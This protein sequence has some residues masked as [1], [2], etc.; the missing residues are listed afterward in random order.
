[1]TANVG[2]K[3]GNFPSV[4]GL[5]RTDASGSFTPLQDAL[6]S[7]LGLVD[8]SGIVQT[9]YSYDPFGNTT[10]SGTANANPSQY[11]GRENEGNGLYFYRARYY[12]PLLGRFVNEDPLGFLG[13]GPNIHA[14]VGD[15]PIDFSDPS[16]L[17]PYWLGYLNPSNYDFSTYNV[18]DTVQDIGNLSESFTNTFTFGSASRLNDA[19]GAGQYVNRCGIGYKLGTAAGIVT[20]VVIIPNISTW[21]KNPLLYEVGSTTV[22]SAVYEGMQGLNAIEKGGYLLANYGWMG[23]LRLAGQAA[24]A[25]E[26]ATTIGTGL[27][28]GGWLAVIAAS[29]VTSSLTKPKCGC[30]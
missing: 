6:G 17:A 9:T 30:K 27:T 20:S 25:G 13:S 5:L 10:V 2:K 3:M 23:T 12:S 14:Y 7:T 16:G 26:Y 4:P 24:L 29:N 19:L 28:P 8:S 22:P 1:M 11:T 15:D 21:V 18:W